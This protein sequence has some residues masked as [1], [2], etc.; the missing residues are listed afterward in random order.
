[1]AAKE[2]VLPDVGLPD[3]LSRDDI[4]QILE[5]RTQAAQNELA[6]RTDAGPDVLYYLAAKGAAAIRRA[7]AANSATPAR[8]NRLLADD[9]DDDVRAELARKIGRLMPDLAREENEKLRELTIETLEK[10]ASDQLPRVRAILAEEIKSLDCIPARV[11]KRLARD[12]EL[13]VSAPI[14]EYSPLL[15]DD[16]LMEIIAT[17]KAK[18]ALSAIA[19]RRFLSANVSDAI[20]TSL[21]IPAVA[22]LLANPDAKIREEAL[23][24]IIEQAEKVRAWHR[25]LA[26]RADLSQRA[27]RRIATFVGAA[28]IEKLSQ[29][30]NIDEET[31]Q[32]LNRQLR[33]RIEAGDDAVSAEDSARHA[34]AAAKAAGRLDDTFVEDAAENGR[35]DVVAVALATLARVPEEIARRMLQFGSAKPLT[36]LVW[37]AGLPMRTAFKIQRFIMKLP[38]DQLL[39]ARDGVR[40]PLTDDEMRWHLG[41]FDVPV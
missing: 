28:L 29:R 2:R 9:T 24:R 7:V 13:M 3:K 11:V 35:R 19:R 14:L 10:L 18:E 34:V 20:A 41:Y 25:P 21:D 1:M 33:A 27:I 26:I 30:H 32:H 4:L 5:E 15:S 40:F 12:A 22:S 38:T 6:G 8:A 37:R 36:A 23:G 17:A 16:D 31:R 39:P